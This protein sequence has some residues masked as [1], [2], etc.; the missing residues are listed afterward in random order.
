MRI[1]RHAKLTSSAS[2]SPTFDLPTWVKNQTTSSPHEET[3]FRSQSRPEE[4][5]GSCEAADKKLL[6]E[7]LNLQSVDLK[8]SSVEETTKEEDEQEHENERAKSCEVKAEEENYEKRI[9]YCR[10]KSTNGWKCK[11]EAKRGHSLC[12]HHLKQRRA[13]HYEP[14]RKPN[15]TTSILDPSFVVVPPSSDFYYYTGFGPLVKRKR[16]GSGAAEAATMPSLS[17]SSSGED[18]HPHTH[19][20]NDAPNDADREK[21][22]GRKPMKSR[23]LKSLL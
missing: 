5:Q 19:D 6:V 23:S 11:R 20:S 17:S 22:R 21:K 18:A 15:R 7:E 4:H 14:R 2:V 3:A 8:P 12:N 16:R 13:Y 1:R 10:K 9:V